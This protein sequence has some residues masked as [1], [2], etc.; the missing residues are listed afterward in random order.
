[1]KEKTKR[2]VQCLKMDEGITLHS[3]VSPEKIHG[4]YR[5]YDGDK[6]F[7]LRL[8][9][10]DEQGRER[11][12]PVPAGLIDDITV[13]EDV[14]A[15]EVVDVVFLDVKTMRNIPMT[16][17]RSDD[18][19]HISIRV[20]LDGEEIER[21]QDALYVRLAATLIENFRSIARN[22]NVEYE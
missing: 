15:G 11:V 17:T 13:D 9:D 10:L 2:Q 21:D 4:Y 5:G 8:D 22:V 7:A 14:K 1:M 16:F 20:Q 19:K 6:L 12:I 18:R 3:D